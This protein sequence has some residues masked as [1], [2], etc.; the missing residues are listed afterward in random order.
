M[1]RCER[2]RCR[3]AV[4]FRRPARGTGAVYGQLAGAYY[5]FADIPKSWREKITKAEVV[6]SLAERLYRHVSGGT[7]R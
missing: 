5:G 3:V 2:Y 1:R 4:G 6:A 7:N